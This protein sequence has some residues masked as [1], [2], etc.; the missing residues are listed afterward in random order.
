MNC[1]LLKPVMFDVDVFQV[2]LECYALQVLPLPLLQTHRLKW[3]HQ[4]HFRFLHFD[5]V[6]CQQAQVKVLRVFVD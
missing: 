2:G 5:Q 6:N 1:L 4:E 3:I